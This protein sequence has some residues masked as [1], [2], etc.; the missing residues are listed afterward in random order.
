MKHVIEPHVLPSLRLLKSLVITETSLLSRSSCDLL[1]KNIP[2]IE[3]MNLGFLSSS[4]DDTIL[5][6]NSQHLTN[7][8]DLTVSKGDWDTVPPSII[9][10]LTRFAYFDGKF[11]QVPGWAQVLSK[12]ATKLTHLELSGC[13]NITDECF[14]YISRI[15]LKSLVLGVFFIT[16][17]NTSHCSLLQ[18]PCIK[19][20]SLTSLHLN[21]VKS[22]K[23]SALQS[24]AS[25][26]T[27][28]SEII[29]GN[30]QNIESDFQSII[31]KNTSLKVIEI[32]DTDMTNTTLHKITKKCTSLERLSLR[33]CHSAT[34]NLQCVLTTCLKLTR[35]ECYYGWYNTTSSTTTV[36]HNTT[37]HN[38]HNTSEE[39][40]IKNSKKKMRRPSIFE[41][42]SSSSSSSSHLLP[43]LPT[44]NTPPSPSSSVSSTHLI[45]NNN[46]NNSSN[47]NEEP[48]TTNSPPQIEK[49]PTEIKGAVSFLEMWKLQG[50]PLPKFNLENVTLYDCHLTPNAVICFSE[51]VP[52]ISR[53]YLGQNPLLKDDCVGVLAQNCTNLVSL[54]IQGCGQV[55]NQGII[56]IANKLTKLEFLNI[57]F[58]SPQISNK[59]TLAI[60]NNLT[61]LTSLDLSGSNEISDNGVKQIIQNCPMLKKVVLLRCRKITSE[62]YF[63]QTKHKCSSLQIRIESSKTI[64]E[65]V[66]WKNDI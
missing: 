65:N 23:P 20:P 55:T 26:C 48:K 15:T 31:K 13:T 66:R 32:A 63:S 57:G 43:S 53:L 58:C 56:T 11:K 24:V 49:N 30:T 52:K 21:G 9:K 33:A 6:S 17:T 4:M 50:I 22:L 34:E 1:L 54:A 51:C 35:L 16:P 37:L 19:I 62:D 25:N 7:L 60:A 28:L 42:L 44:P 59:S 38:L 3:T 40:S 36:P 46:S 45:N 27:E 14:H 18:K 5:E 12:N 61:N 39:S 41:G 29:L 8:R 10:N 64:D 2:L 47:I